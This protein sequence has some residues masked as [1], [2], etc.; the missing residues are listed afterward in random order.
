MKCG[1]PTPVNEMRQVTTEELRRKL[2]EVINRAAYGEDP[3]VVTR[4]GRKIAAV[5]SILDLIL[6]DRVKVQ[7]EAYRQEMASR[8]PLDPKHSQWTMDL[9]ALLG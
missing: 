5:V 8:D 9:Q 7:R 2:A 4:R 1:P 6:L 3:V